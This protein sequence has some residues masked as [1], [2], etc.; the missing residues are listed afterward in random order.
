MLFERINYCNYNMKAL[1]FF[2][3]FIGIYYLV[4]T[5]GWI[6]LTMKH[7][8]QMA[9]SCGIYLLIYYLLSR[10]RDFVYKMAKNIS[11]TDSS[12][13][14]N[15]VSFQNDQLKYSL[16][17]KQGHRCHKCRN[18][19]LIK[20]IDNY[21]INYKVPLH[22]GGSNTIHNLGIYCPECSAFMK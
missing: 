9:I 20:N 8:I 1:L 5:R 10:Q 13:F 3:S 15:Q 11:N 14:N 4:Y 22:Y 7:H 12:Q 2:C 21:A 16:S 17:E 18:P 6:E 19:I